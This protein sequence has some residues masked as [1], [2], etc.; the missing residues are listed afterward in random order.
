MAS[1]SPTSRRT[2][3]APPTSDLYSTVVIH[4]DVVSPTTMDD[5]IDDYYDYDDEDS[6]L[7]PLL[8]RLPKDFGTILDSGEDSSSAGNISGTMIVK[9]D[10][11]GRS[12]SSYSSP[13]WKP[14]SAPLFDRNSA[15]SPRKRIEAEEDED[16]KEEGEGDFSTF[17]VRSG[18]RETVTGTVVRRESGGGSTM[19]MA[20]ASMQAMGELGFGKKQQQGKGTSSGSSSSFPDESSCRYGQQKGS[21]VSSSSIPEYCITREDPSTKY[22]LLNEL[23]KGSYGA[24]YKAR[25]IKT[26]ELVAIKVIS[27]SEG[28][29][30]YEEIR[31]E[32][33]MLQQ[34]SHPN[35]VRYLGSYQGEEYLWI[36]MEYCG[37]GSVADLMNNTDEPL[38]EIQIAYI[39]RE[40]LKGLSYLH[41]IFKVH[42]DIK[43]GN[44]L[45]TE[46]G[47]V[48]LGDF[49]VAAQLTRTM[50]KRNT[51][52][53]TPHWMAPEVIQES[54]YDGKV[55]VWALGV[56]AIEMAE[57][58]KSGEYM[59]P[60]IVKELSLSLSFPG[61]SSKVNSTSYESNQKN[62]FRKRSLVFHDFIAKCLTKEPRPRPTASELLK[63]KFIERCK[64]GPSVMLLKI[65]KARQSRASMALEAQNIPSGTFIPGNTALG[66]P[67]VNEDYG[68]TVP[69]RPHDGLQGTLKQSVPGAVELAGEGDFGTV[70][71]HAG[72]EKDKKPTQ[73]SASNAI[74]ASPGPWHAEART[75]SGAGD[76][77]PDPWGRNAE[78]VDADNSQIRSQSVAQTIQASSPSVFTTPDQKN[79][80]SQALIGSG[81]GIS[82]DTFKSETASRKALDKLWSIYAAGN[83]VPIPFLR[84]TDIS[85]IALLSDNVLGG[86]QQGSGGSG[87][88]AEEAVQE[89]FCGDGQWK[90]GRRGQNEVPL[91]P[92]VYQRLTSSSTLMNLTQALAYHKI[93]LRTMGGSPPCTP[94]REF[95][96]VD[97]PTAKM[98]L[99]GL[100]QDRMSSSWELGMSMS[101]VPFKPIVGAPNLCYEEM[102]LQELQAAQEQ[103]TIQNLCDTLRTILRLKR[104]GKAS[105]MHT[106]LLY[107]TYRGP[108]RTSLFSTPPP[109]AAV[110]SS[111]STHQLPLTLLN[112][113]SPFPSSGSNYSHNPFRLRLVPSKP[114][115]SFCPSTLRLISTTTSEDTGEIQETPAEDE[116]DEEVEPIDS[117]EE[118][119]DAEPEIGDGGDG[120]GV[121]LQNCH[122][123]E[124]VLSLAHEV[125]LQF[126]DG[127]ELFSFKTTPR[128]YIYVRLDKL[129]HEYGCPS[130]DE[131]ES[132]SRQYKKR[133]DEV[134]A[135]G[136]IPDDLAL[137]VSSPGAERLLKVPDDLYRFKDMPMRVDYIEDQDARSPE[138]F[139]VFYLESI[140]TETGRCV[141][142]LADVKE[143]RDPSAK[144]RPLSRKLKDWR[145]DLPYAMFKR[146]TLYLDY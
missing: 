1:S 51:F 49:G 21:K 52:I 84:A 86:L 111:V 29:E 36:V 78:G 138:K 46:Q 11:S 31:G 136:E 44:I 134:G 77:S 103:Q 105:R 76:K 88:I 102:P 94:S 57:I 17:V 54:R 48:K 70:I 121:V 28:E 34:C 67:K 8:K 58:L 9:T 73:T 64:S 14:R 23:G 115:S 43:G 41:S 98:E 93:Y 35:V 100:D 65:E 24:V 3:K 143:N 68:D 120:G 112:P 61:T 30:G 114:T 45:L 141:W 108:R 106:L 101:G 81:G 18:E 146:V 59:I 79:S 80:I 116:T 119:D 113:N 32:I 99:F 123:G 95:L 142:R 91:P 12:S 38:E 122:W 82:S 22:E 50:S 137:E 125:L 74:E 6:S 131:I 117:W 10:R 126:G 69:S 107:R 72:D 26:S 5:P 139:G 129:A 145:L 109:S 75:V 63:H 124:R 87:N 85:P 42:R 118:E 89:L 7:P 104:M 127:M 97:G 33:E 39:C 27:L 66:G 19:S 135:S 47:E 13:A 96:Y 2:R 37:G 92:S 133:L 110:A 130:M 4:D 16:E 128:G 140:E 132:Y 53:G 56:S 90:K 25:D 60:H 144:G 20:V 71:V 55:D 15:A 83:T 40:A 62:C